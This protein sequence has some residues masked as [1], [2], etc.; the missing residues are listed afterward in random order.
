[1]ATKEGVIRVAA[2]SIR[3][4][5]NGYVLKVKPPTE[6]VV[7]YA[8]TLTFTDGKKPKESKVSVAPYGQYTFP[9][10]ATLTAWLRKNIKHGGGVE[11]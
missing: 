2:V 9:D 11:L 4:V 10:F 8:Y 6:P 7:G 5:R 3:A 1:M